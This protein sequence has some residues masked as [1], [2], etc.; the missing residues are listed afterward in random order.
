MRRKK[1]MRDKCR[2]CGKP[3]PMDHVARCATCTKTHRRE[4]ANHHLTAE[5]VAVLL[6]D[7]ELLR[8]AMPWDREEAKRADRRAEVLRRLRG[9]S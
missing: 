6:D 2:E 5:E 4:M 7:D 3:K 1:I 8:N 9:G